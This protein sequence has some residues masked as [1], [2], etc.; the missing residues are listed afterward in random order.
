[1]ICPACGAENRAGATV[2]QQLRRSAAGRGGARGAQGRDGA[3]LRRHR[4]DGARRAARPRAASRGDGASTSPLRAPLIER[5][6]GTVEKFIGDAVMAV[7]GVPTVH[8]D[9]ALARRPR[10]PIELRDG[11]QIDVRIGVNT[12]EVVTG[13]GRDAR[14]G[15]R[16]QR[17]RAARA[18]GR[19]RRGAARRADHTRSCATPSTPSSCRRS[20]AKG[21]SEPVT[22]Y[23]VGAVTG[24]TA[25]A[26]RTDAPLVGRV[27]ERDQLEDAWERCTL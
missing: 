9:D 8:E 2:L 13:H 24:E 22:A 27:R 21:K 25:F 20:Q 16:G 3:L 15:R 26:R 11:A 4:L 6:G 19:R 5:H 23:R 12:G 17:R 7:F 10:A 18:G 14:H 1:M